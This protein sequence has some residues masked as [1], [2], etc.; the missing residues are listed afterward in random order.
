MSFPTRNQHGSQVFSDEFQDLSQRLFVL[1]GRALTHALPLQVQSYETSPN[2]EVTCSLTLGDTGAQLFYRPTLI[3]PSGS[4]PTF[5]S[6]IEPS[7]TQQ[8]DLVPHPASSAS[9]GDGDPWFSITWPTPPLGFSKS[10]VVIYSPWGSYSPNDA[11]RLCLINICW[12]NELS[13]MRWRENLVA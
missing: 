1:P 10:G 7:L 12:I 2:P 11:F 6:S 3:L 4:P 8:E 13:W 5:P 9:C